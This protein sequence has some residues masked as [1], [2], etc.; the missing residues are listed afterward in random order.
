[1]L[2]LW[3]NHH[4]GELVTCISCYFWCCDLPQQLKMLDRP[5]RKGLFMVYLHFNQH[6]ACGIVR[7]QT[8]KSINP[9]RIPLWESFLISTFLLS[10]Y[11]AL[12]FNMCIILLFY[13]HCTWIT[14]INE[15]KLYLQLNLYMYSRGWV[16]INHLFVRCKEWTISRQCLYLTMS[17]TFICRSAGV[18]VNSTQMIRI[19][20]IHSSER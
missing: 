2:R 9:V 4:L 17:L 10:F 1:M 11:T 19:S 12:T 18:T 20:T 3:F 16:I 8:F 13:V 7:V 6:C 5:A 15:R 14:T